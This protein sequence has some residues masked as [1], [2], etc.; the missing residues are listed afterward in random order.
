MAACSK[1][2]VFHLLIEI[3]NGMSSKIFVF[4]FALPPTLFKFLW[5][6]NVKSFP[7]HWHRC[8]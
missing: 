8:W 5:N 1:I 2:Y 4:L 6:E 7:A 3:K